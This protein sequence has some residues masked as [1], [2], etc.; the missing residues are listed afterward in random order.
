M[1]VSKKCGFTGFPWRMVI[2]YKVIKSPIDLAECKNDVRSFLGRSEKGVYFAA[3]DPMDILR[4]WILRES[5]DH[6]GKPP[7]CRVPKCLPCASRNSTRQTVGT[8]QCL[9]YLGYHIRNKQKKYRI[10]HLCRVHWPRHTANGPYF[11][12]CNDLGTRQ[13]L[14]LCRVP[15]P[16]DTRQTSLATSAW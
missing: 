11:A 7:D 14:S 12:V 16:G 5:S 3:I 8:R 6:Y 1:D 9:Y 15:D 4:V 10:S 2:K 13:R